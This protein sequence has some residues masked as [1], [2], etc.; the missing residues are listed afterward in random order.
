MRLT[1]S[2]Y[3]G[4]ADSWG[5]VGVAADVQYVV[6]W[7]FIRSVVTVH[8]VERDVEEIYTLQISLG[9]DF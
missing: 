7:F 3:I 8:Q 6:V 9:C 4:A 2:S 5:M 1:A